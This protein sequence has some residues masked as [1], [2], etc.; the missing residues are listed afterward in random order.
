MLQLLKFP[1]TQ[2]G[3]SAW[4]WMLVA[5]FVVILGSLLLRVIPHY[6][7]FSAVQSMFEALPE[8]THSLPRNGIREHF[9]K[10]FRIEGL[11]MNAREQIVVDRAK[12]E[13]TVSIAYEIREPLLYNADIVLSFSEQRTFK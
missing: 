4:T 2:R 5:V 3:A 10:R 11:D 9:Q 8:D 6:L 1:Q 13:T 12:G 7:Q